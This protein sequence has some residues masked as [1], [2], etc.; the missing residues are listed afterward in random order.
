MPGNSEER[1]GRHGAASG[2]THHLPRP[3]E[4][5]EWNDVVRGTAEVAA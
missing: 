2:A 4:I 3:V 1:L 5:G